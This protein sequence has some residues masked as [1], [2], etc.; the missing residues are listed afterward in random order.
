MLLYIKYK[1]KNMYKP[2]WEIRMGLGYNYDKQNI[3]TH[4]VWFPVSFG[5]GDWAQFWCIDGW[6][7]RKS[8]V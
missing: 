7:E 4:K 5:E 2:T 6:P 8:L 1:R 3:L